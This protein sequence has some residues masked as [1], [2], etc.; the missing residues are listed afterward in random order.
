MTDPNSTDAVKLSFESSFGDSR[1]C[2]VCGEHVDSHWSPAMP[3]DAE[4]QELENLR[5][6]AEPARLIVRLP[7]KASTVRD[8][9]PFSQLAEAVD[10]LEKWTADQQEQQT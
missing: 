9:A 1:L 7:I 10:N 6:L 2:D 5:A 8:Y 4:Q 3:T